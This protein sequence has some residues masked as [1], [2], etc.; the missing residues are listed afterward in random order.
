MCDDFLNCIKEN[1]RN[2][3]MIDRSKIKVG[4]AIDVR[5]TVNKIFPNGSVETTYG[6]VFKN[7]EI[8]NHIPRKIKVGDKVQSKSTGNLYEVLSIYI[9]DKSNIYWVKSYYNNLFYSLEESEIEL[10]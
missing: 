10:V 1:E 5:Y 7:D 8:V 9:T 3:T 2:N 6:T 4:D